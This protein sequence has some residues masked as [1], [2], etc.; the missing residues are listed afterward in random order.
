MSI[1][2]LLSRLDKVRPV[3]KHQWIACCP[4]HNDRS[5]SLSV[6]EKDDG[7]ILIKCF[8]ECGASEI[9]EAIGLGLEDLFEDKISHHMPKTRSAVSPRQ[10][11]LCLVPETFCIALIG[12][13]MSQG[14]PP[15]EKTLQTLITACSR[16]SA[17]HSYMENL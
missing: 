15:D 7:R 4:A 12:K 1:G 10:V 11:L 13:Q 16:V 14:I 2:N 5:P 17:A 8:A 9:M 6:T 3:G